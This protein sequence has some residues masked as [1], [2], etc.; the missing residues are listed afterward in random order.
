LHYISRF[1]FLLGKLLILVAVRSWVW[2]EMLR[3]IGLFFFIVY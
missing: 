1:C 2:G 3:N